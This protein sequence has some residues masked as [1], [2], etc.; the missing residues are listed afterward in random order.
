M[1][2]IEESIITKAPAKN[3]W[4]AWIDLY[5]MKTGGKFKDGFSGHIIERGRKVPFKI[6]DVIKGEGFTTIWS[7]F[8]VKMIFKYQ[9]KQQAK[10]S[11]ITCE[12]KFGGPFGWIAKI[13][14]KGKV[15]T[16]LA[17]S[18]EQF[19]NQLDMSQKKVQIRT[20]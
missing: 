12:V 6:T 9:V 20:F 19:A 14:L 10:G 8:L 4:K 5:Q 17:N 11:L 1:K 2:P 7:S 13:F 15:R 3:V 18:L 16:N